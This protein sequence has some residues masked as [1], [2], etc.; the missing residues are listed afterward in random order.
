MKMPRVITG[1]CPYC[2]RHVELAIERVRR[3]KASELRRGQRQFRRVM[4]G[5]GGYPRPRPNREKPTKRVHLRYRCKECKKAHQR[6]GFRAKQ[7]ELVEA[8]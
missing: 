6:P 4:S 5:Y 8:Q 3:R 7:F 2:R 1:Y